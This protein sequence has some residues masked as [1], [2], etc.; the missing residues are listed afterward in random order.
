MNRATTR[1]IRIAT[2]ASRLAMWQAN[3]TADLL[4]AHDSHLQIELIEVS[5]IGD[6]D[7][8]ESLQSLGGQGVFTREVQRAVLD[9]RADLAVHSLKDLPTAAT[10]G[11][12]LASVPSRGSTVDA[13]VLPEGR[14]SGA[15]ESVTESA[16]E[17]WH[18][19]LP[20]EARIGTGSI[21]RQAQLLHHRPD[22][23]MIEIRGNVETRL[24]KLDDGD[25]GALILAK[26]G[27]QRLGLDHRIS[28][29]LAPPI[30]YP[31]VGQGA[32]GIECR[33]EDAD[34]LE[35]LNTIADEDSLAT[36]IAE[37]SLLHTLH[38]GCH[39][40]VGVATRVESGELFLEAVVLSADGQQRLIESDAAPMAQAES[41]GREVA[42]RLIQE[43]ADAL[44]D[45]PSK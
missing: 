25:C 12:M 44:I 7:K 13:L 19:V 39:A 29:E 20:S 16:N 14:D 22:L 27:L 4:R 21:R 32:L 2:R 6:R 40:P 24:R 5:T 45:P 15:A 18:G 37:R 33:A 35:I 10:D 3:H 1:T 34:L 36:V 26:A 11:L 43:G 41:L 28:V 30:L 38:A 9:G 42:E 23:E 8:R 31:A 17:S